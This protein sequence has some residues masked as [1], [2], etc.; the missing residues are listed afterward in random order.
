MMKTLALSIVFAV[1]LSNPAL[2]QSS[3]NPPA[4]VSAEVIDE[5]LI[6]EATTLEDRA[7]MLRRCAGPPPKAMIAAD[8]PKQTPVPAPVSVADRIEP[9][10]N[11]GG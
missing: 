2:A 7:A 6:L 10:V 9:A 3:P 11:T 8:K 4:D 5:S 1:G